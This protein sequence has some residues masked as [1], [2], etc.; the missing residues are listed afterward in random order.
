MLM[1]QLILMNCLNLLRK[2]LLLQ[3]TIIS[4]MHMLQG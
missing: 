4:T 1:Q 2:A 3:P